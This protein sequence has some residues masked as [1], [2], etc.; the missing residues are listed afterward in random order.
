MVLHY[1]VREGEMI[2]YYDVMS[3]YPFV[4]KYLKFPIG[5]PKIHVGDACRDK[6]AMLSKEGLVKCTV[7]PLNRL[8]QPV[9][10]F[11]SIKKLILSMQDERSRMQ[12]FG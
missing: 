5:H 3:L 6:K 12:L 1:P 2:Q 10:P 11:R 4:C 9:L 7:L 8:Y